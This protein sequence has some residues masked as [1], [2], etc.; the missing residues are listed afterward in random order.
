MSPFSRFAEGPA[1]D[2]APRLA[3]CLASRFSRIF[4]LALRPTCMTD[5]VTARLKIYPLPRDHGTWNIVVQC[6]RNVLC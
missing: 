6:I 1:L 4:S 2:G 3:L 5:K